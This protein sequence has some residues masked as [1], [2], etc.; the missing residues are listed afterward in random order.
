MSSEVAPTCRADRERIVLGLDD[1]TVG[2]LDGFGRTVGR[3]ASTTGG[4]QSSACWQH[5]GRDVGG[6]VPRVTPSVSV[7]LTEAAWRRA[8][9]RTALARLARVLVAQC[10]VR[11]VIHLTHVDIDWDECLR[12]L[13]RLRKEALPNANLGRVCIEAPFS[14]LDENAKQGLFQLGVE[15][16]YLAGWWPGCPE[17]NYSRVDRASLFD[18]ASFGFYVPVIWYV[19]SANVDEL[20]SAVEKG[21]NA[22]LNS[23][24]ALPLVSASPYFQLENAPAIPNAERYAELLARHY[25]RHRNYDQSFEPISELAKLIGKGGWNN[26][27]GLPA[28]PRILFTAEDKINL[29]RHIPSFSRPWLPVAAVSQMQEAELVESFVSSHRTQ[30]DWERNAFCGTCDWRHVCGGMDVPAVDVG[31]PEAIANVLHVHC[32]HRK[33]FLEAFA[34]MKVSQLPIGQP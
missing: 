3:F 7:H 34:R 21:L 23:G 29:Y 10:P 6:A 15:L 27:V 33:I 31:R 4:A 19:H 9:S 28:F 24:F 12:E 32:E 30:F 1:N 26:V 14:A 25:Q 17:S 11:I 22:N 20:D 5:K 2:V 13:L 16:R 18:L 8:A